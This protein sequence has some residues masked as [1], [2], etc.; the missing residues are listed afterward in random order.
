MQPKFKKGYY[1]NLLSWKEFVTL[2]NIR[3]LMRC[4]RIVI[5]KFKEEHYWE[6]SSWTL[7]QKCSP[8]LLLKNF[9]QNNICYLKYMSRC[10]RKV[11]DLAKRF[12]EEYNGAADAHIYICRNTSII[13]PFGIHYDENPNVIVQCEGETNFKVWDIIK[14]I[15]NPP[16]KKHDMSITD[17]P[18]LDV[19]MKPG[20]AIWIPKYYPHLATSNTVRMSV[21]FPIK[22]N[23][24]R[25]PREW[26]EL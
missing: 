20:D 22:C 1:P 5:P 24:A 23:G 15:D 3:P 6:N 14:D 9:F 18:L 2:I 12:E 19:D 16:S 17:T 26:I 25:Q 10:S 4:D 13:H 21:S 11:N 8:P 7:D